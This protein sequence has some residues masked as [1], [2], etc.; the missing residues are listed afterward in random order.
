M[1][2]SCFINGGLADGVNVDKHYNSLPQKDKASQ[3][4]N[5]LLC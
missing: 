4:D 5:V 3:T 2:A 1:C